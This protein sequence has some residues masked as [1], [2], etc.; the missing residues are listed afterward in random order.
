MKNINIADIAREAGVSQATVTRAL[1]N[2]GYVSAQKRKQ[3]LHAVDKLGY[4]PNK[5]ASGLRQNKSN[6]IGHVLPASSEN[7]FFARI[8]DAFNKAAEDAGYNVLTAVTLMD[9]ARERAM[10]QNWWALWWTPSSLPP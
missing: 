8:G 1:H 9:L 3:V 5:V 10:V 6:F 7:P 2:S 4:V